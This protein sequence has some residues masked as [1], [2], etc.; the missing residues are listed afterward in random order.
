[1]VSLPAGGALRE[2]AHGFAGYFRAAGQLFGVPRAL[3][4][5]L[6][7]MLLSSVLLAGGTWAALH[8]AVDP[9]LR[10]L[11][12]DSDDALVR[13]FAV[14][15][16]AIAAVGLVVVGVWLLV[17]LLHPLLLAPF[18]D[19]LAAAVERQ[20]LG[21][22]PPRSGRGALAGLVGLLGFALLVALLQAALIVVGFVLAP[23][24]VGLVLVSVLNAWLAALTW[25]DHPLARREF[26]TG[27]RLAFVRRH[28][29]LA[30]GLGLGYQVGL[31][32]PV[33]N[34]LLAGPAAAVAATR[35][36]FG[37]FGAG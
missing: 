33:F 4:L 30:L 34:L 24:G 2:F 26:G 16:L 35:L 12:Q 13:F 14:F 6:V 32:I 21:A 5:L 23:S 29:A 17:P 18:L 11:Q 36:V 3:P 25:L 22:A 10:W 19:P 9:V 20:V 1:M 27:A 15:A 31:W 28:W 7:P 37:R 8:Y